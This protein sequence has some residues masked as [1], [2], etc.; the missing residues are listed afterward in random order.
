[1][2]RF[3]RLKIYFYVSFSAG[4]QLRL[5]LR[6]HTH[7]F[8]TATTQK[9]NAISCTVAFNKRRLPTSETMFVLHLETVNC[10]NGKQPREVHLASMKSHR[11]LEEN[12]YFASQPSG[13]CAINNDKQLENSEFDVR[14]ECI[15]NASDG[16]T[17]NLTKFVDEQETKAN[18]EDK[19]FSVLKMK[20]R[21]K[22]WKFIF[23]LVD[24]RKVNV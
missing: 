16:K 5:L 19:S 3:L 11:E 6:W 17:D 13:V 15:R 10:T 7:A 9:K 1:M 18:E 2:C 12:S 24:T 21:I 8:C 14:I 4:F 23:N 22:K 20:F